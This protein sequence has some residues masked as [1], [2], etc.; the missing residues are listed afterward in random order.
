ML[1]GLICVYDILL[2]VPFIFVDSAKCQF[3]VAPHDNFRMFDGN[4]SIPEVG[5][6]RRLVYLQLYAP[7]LF[8]YPLFYGPL[9]FLIFCCACLLTL[10]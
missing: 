6:Y 10:L 7:P 5:I 3:A 9:K 2:C 4:Q 1:Y 8:S